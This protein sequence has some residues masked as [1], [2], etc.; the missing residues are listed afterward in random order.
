[1]QDDPAKNAYPLGRVLL[2]TKAVRYKVIEDPDAL[3]ILPL[4]IG[5]KKPPELFAQDRLLHG[6]PQ[7]FPALKPDAGR[8]RRA[9]GKQ[10]P[11]LAFPRSALFGRFVKR[12]TVQLGPL[13]PA[14]QAILSKAGKPLKYQRELFIRGQRLDQH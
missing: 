8:G 10:P 14:P 5:S 13:A 3:A 2:K 6:F 4:E 12:R 7:V 11:R 1:M 9:S